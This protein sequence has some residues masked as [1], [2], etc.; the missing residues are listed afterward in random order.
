MA[1][2]SLHVAHSPNILI[3]STASPLPAHNKGFDTVLGMKLF[4]VMGLAALFGHTA[5]DVSTW[6]LM[7]SLC[8]LLD[9]PAAF[10]WL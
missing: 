10:L 4:S 9:C 3:S 5:V 7:L 1:C 2:S 6:T 8:Q